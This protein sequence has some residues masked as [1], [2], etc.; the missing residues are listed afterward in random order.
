MKG[1]VSPYTWKGVSEERDEGHWFAAVVVLEMDGILREES[2]LVGPDLVEDEFTTILRDH[3]GDER[4]V[5]DIIEFCRPRM[6]V[7]G[8]QAAWAEEANSCET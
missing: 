5:G 7:R 3:T 2:G 8:V 4:S 6:G 1:K